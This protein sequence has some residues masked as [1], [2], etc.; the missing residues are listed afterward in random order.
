MVALSSLCTCKIVLM[1]TTILGGRVRD[2]HLLKFYELFKNL[3]NY[4][5]FCMPLV[6]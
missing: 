6:V 3:F 1:K 5:S 4:F 2:A